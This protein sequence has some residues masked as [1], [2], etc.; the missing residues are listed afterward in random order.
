MQSIYLNNVKGDGSKAEA[1][2]QTDGESLESVKLSGAGS[3]EE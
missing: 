3:G 1:D 2:N